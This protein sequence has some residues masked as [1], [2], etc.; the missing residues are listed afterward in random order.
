MRDVLKTEDLDIPEG[1]TVDIK[2]RL[3][4]V[5]GPRGTLT[6]NVRHINM[7]INLQK[8]KTNKVLLQ[9]WQGGRK[10][11]ACLRTVRS[12][13]E[14]MI[15]GVTKGFLYKMRAVYAH[16]PINCIIQESGAAVEIRNFLGEKTVRH[17]KML[18]GVTVSESKAQKDELI[19]EGNDVQN[20]SQSAASIQG[21][22]RVRNKDIRKFLDGIYV[23]DKGTVL[24][25]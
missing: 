12:L 19:L 18:E 1:V 25:D 4:T 23:S 20:V 9:V 13:I 14:N 5:T 22:C 8:T 11:V 15:I 17:V 7:D 10:H 21:I 24:Q 2:A 3:I 16:F 6:K